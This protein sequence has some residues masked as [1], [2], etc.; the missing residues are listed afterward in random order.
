MKLPMR[1][2]L[3]ALLALLAS[4][5]REPADL[6]DDHDHDHDHE[7]SPSD[8]IA[9]PPQVRQNLGI[10]FVRAER[11]R[12]AATLRVP[13]QFEQ[14]PGTLHEYRTPVAGR[15]TLATAPLQAVQKG[16]VLYSIDAPAWREAQRELGELAATI[17]VTQARVDAMQ[18]LREA[19]ERHEQSLRAALAI[20]TERLAQLTTLQQDV[21]GQA[22]ELAA[23]RLKQAELRAE[24][25]EVE[26]KDAELAATAA[27]QLASLAAS[28]DRFALMMASAATL[29]GRSMAELTSQTEGVPAWRQI[30]TLAVRANASG[31]VDLVPVASG[32]QIDAHGLVVA[33]RDPKQLRFFARGLQSDLSRLRDGLPA[34]VLWAAADA[35]EPAATGTLQIGTSADPQARTVALFVTALTVPENARPGLAGYLEVETA[36]GGATEV[37]IPSA[38]VLTDGL[39]RVLFRRDPRNPDQ[40]IRAE[41]DCGLDDGR[42]LEIKSGLAE[43]DEIVLAGA[44]EL[45]LASSGAAPKGGHFHADGTFHAEGHK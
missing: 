29:A 6:H 20:A 41:A 31:I 30:D 2:V 12:V 34:R 18:P 38:C 37:A 21:G 1:Y 5:Q 35:S 26:E 3:L 15:I 39:Q 10:T 16:D 17:T 23:V 4:C 28:K 45:M 24:I 27:E 13:G 9:T 7:A 42:W 33:V 14:V 8:R 19:H 11:R 40:V 43:G 22:N 36:S 44:Y 32:A 25:A